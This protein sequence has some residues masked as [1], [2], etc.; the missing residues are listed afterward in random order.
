MNE[1]LTAKDVEVK[2]TWSKLT[3]KK[4]MDGDVKEVPEAYKI[5]EEEASK[6]NG[7]V[8]D[9]DTFF[10]ND[11]Y[12]HQD[13][14][15]GSGDKKIY[16]FRYTNSGDD[17]TIKNMNNVIFANHCWQM[18]RTTDTGG[19]KMIYNGPP[20][21]GETGHEECQSSTSSSRGYHIGFYSFTT[22]YFNSGVAYG[23][24]FVY[25]AENNL[26]RLDVNKNIYTN[27]VMSTDYNDLI[28]KYTCNSIDADS[29]C[30]ILYLIHSYSY[31]ENALAVSLRNNIS[32]SSIG[33]GNYSTNYTAPSDIGYMYNKRYLTDTKTFATTDK[34]YFSSSY[35]YKLNESTGKN[36]YFLDGN[37]GEKSFDE[38]LQTRYTCWKTTAEESC[39]RISYI[40]YI[41]AGGYRKKVYYVSLNGGIGPVEALT[42]M[43]SADNVNMKD[44][45]IKFLVDKWY[46]HYISDSDSNKL[47]NAV[48]CNDRSIRNLGGW[49]PEGSIYVSLLF[50]NYN[51]TANLN[52][53]NETDRFSADPD[54]VKAKLKYPIGVISSP[55][56]RLLNNNSLAQTGNRYWTISPYQFMYNNSADVFVVTSEGKLEDYHVNYTTVVGATTIRPL[57]SLKAGT[58]FTSG[59]GSMSEPYRVD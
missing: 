8:K 36:E 13:A 28:G 34:Y 20:E 41:P 49:S 32:Y 47:E 57:I 53:E 10:A 58:I 7:V 31:G 30:E 6:L 14:Y 4:S 26:F 18:L 46:E 42:E 37:I 3:I 54:N 39:E 40:Y 50:K 15:D 52:C 59:D 56:V 22:Q 48:F 16:F 1:L 25:D 43:L 11:N 9:Y 5:F 24:D 55:E 12:S 45:R 51:G 33:S 21:I 23:D 19:V 27:K 2:A 29:T 35:E 44:S 38:N 17:T